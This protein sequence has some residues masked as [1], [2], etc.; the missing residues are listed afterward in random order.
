MKHN[1]KNNFKI[2]FK[3]GTYVE[4]TGSCDAIN[5]PTIKDELNWVNLHIT[6][7]IRKQGK[8]EEDVKYLTVNVSFSEKNEE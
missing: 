2:S 5:K 4:S 7:Q 3:D 1:S 8:T 6:K